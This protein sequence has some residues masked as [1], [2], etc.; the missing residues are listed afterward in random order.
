MK[1]S[2][3]FVGLLSPCSTIRLIKRVR[4]KFISEGSGVLDTYTI[5][6]TVFPE[7]FTLIPFLRSSF[8]YELIGPPEFDLYSGSLISC[9]KTS[10]VSLYTE[11]FFLVFLSYN[12]QDF[13][14][15]PVLYTHRRVFDLLTFLCLRGTIGGLSLYRN[16]CGT[17]IKF[18]WIQSECQFWHSLM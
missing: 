7:T 18:L 13:Y 4:G 6:C 8:L 5:Q 9:K 11:I 14:R 10:W 2:T 17:K 15:Y 1:N 3:N 16:D 12:D